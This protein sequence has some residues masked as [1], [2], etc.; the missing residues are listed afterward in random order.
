MTFLD[1]SKAFNYVQRE[2]MFH[3]DFNLCITGNLFASLV[4]YLG[5]EINE[6][7]R[8]L[9]M[10]QHSLNLLMYTNDIA[11]TA[12]DVQAAQAEINILSEWCIRWGM[13]VKTKTQV[14]HICHHQKP[15]C[16]K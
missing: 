3:K 9:R 4:N 2:F 16:K 10:N 14:V 13:F 5:H 11:C 6:L 15:V 12:L 8:G 7:N 1:F